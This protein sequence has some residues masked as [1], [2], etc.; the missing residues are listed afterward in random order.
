M[1]IPKQIVKKVER[2]TIN[3]E[4]TRKEIA[5]YLGV[6]ATY[7]TNSLDSGKMS[8]DKYEKLLSFLE[9]VNAR[10]KSRKNRERKLINNP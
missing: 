1:Q 6:N 4:C 9:L 2:F 8:V 3:S 5:D 10:I 7:I